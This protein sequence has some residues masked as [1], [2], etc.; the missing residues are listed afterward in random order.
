MKRILVTC[1]VA[2]L[3]AGT[4]AFAQDLHHASEGRLSIGSVGSTVQQVS[5][6]NGARYSELYRVK[7]DHTLTLV[8]RTALSDG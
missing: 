8:S 1:A 7:P 3:G 6:E 4:L 2:L 5:V